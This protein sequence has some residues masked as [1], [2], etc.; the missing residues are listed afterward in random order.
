[1]AML[2]LIA[3][4]FPS[5]STVLLS[6]PQSVRRSAAAAI[7]ELGCCQRHL[8]H[9]CLKSTGHL[10]TLV[11]CAT[12][13]G[14]TMCHHLNQHR[15]KGKEDQL[16]NYAPP[17]THPCGCLLGPSLGD[18]PAIGRPRM[19]TGAVTAFHGATLSMSGTE[20][21][22]WERETT[23]MLFRLCSLDCWMLP[24]LPEVLCKGCIS[25]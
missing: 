1:M 8:D 21:D 18:Q 12:T 16:S 3:S 6:M 25:H 23:V 4:H 5:Q 14:T 10:S 22:R 9:N 17:T 20:G 15:V 11:G 13:L 24:I 2:I 7:R 19:A